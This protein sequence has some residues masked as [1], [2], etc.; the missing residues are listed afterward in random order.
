[1]IK[2]IINVLPLSFDRVIS[3]PPLIL[4]DS[5]SASRVHLRSQGRQSSSSPTTLVVYLSLATFTV[6]VLARVL[7]NLD[8]LR[9]ELS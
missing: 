7:L 9:R 4:F 1:M 3:L 2:Y 5:L 8:Y 6:T